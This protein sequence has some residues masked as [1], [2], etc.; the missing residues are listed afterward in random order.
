MQSN[1]QLWLGAGMCP[2]GQ[3]EPE[4]GMEPLTHRQ[5]GEGL[6]AEGVQ[7]L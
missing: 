2:W 7:D 4:C 6:Y 5:Q 3:E 1:L